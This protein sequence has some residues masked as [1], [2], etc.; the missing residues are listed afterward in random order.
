MAEQKTDIKH[1]G[2]E[3]LKLEISAGSI[4][5]KQFCYDS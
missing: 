4:E 3:K 1:V 2:A 5:T